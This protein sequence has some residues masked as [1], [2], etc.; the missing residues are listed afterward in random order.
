MQVNW[1]AKALEAGDTGSSLST[2]DAAQVVGTSLQTNLRSVNLPM[3]LKSILAESD[4]AA[5]PLVINGVLIQDTGTLT[6][7]CG[8]GG[9][10]DY[11][12]SYDDESG[13]FNATYWFHEYCDK[14]SLISGLVRASGASQH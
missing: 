3:N 13:D 10:V 14:G 2:M 1:Q 8:E 4:P 12:K 5:V 7:T 6:D 9:F 11:D